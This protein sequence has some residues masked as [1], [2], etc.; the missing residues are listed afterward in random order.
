MSPTKR[1]RTFI[2]A[3]AFLLALFVALSAACNS[4]SAPEGSDATRVPAQRTPGPSGTLSVGFVTRGDSTVLDG[5]IFG[6]ENP[7]LVILSHM[8]P[9]DQTAWFP[10][11]EELVDAGYAVLTFDF[12]GYGNSL[13]AKDDGKLDEDLAA[14]LNFMRVRD[15]ERI[16]LVGASMGGTASMIVAAQEEVSG[17]ISISSPSEFQGHDARKAVGDI[18]EP[19]LLLASEDDAAARISL[20]ELLDASGDSAETDVYSGGEHGT[21]MFLGENANAVRERIFQFL[22]DHSEN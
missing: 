13:A 7:V 2:L 21:D 14:A 22:A 1:T 3:T 16:F 18:E 9:N 17:V 10:F 12:R 11:A 5:H 19:L 8:R 4:S 6:D 15:R 20:V